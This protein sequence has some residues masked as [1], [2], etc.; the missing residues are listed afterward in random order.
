MRVSNQMTVDAS[1]SD[2]YR[3]MDNLM[4]SQQ[5]LSSQ[6]RVNSPSDDPFSAYKAIGA[7]SQVSIIE[8]YSKNIDDI[9][10][11]VGATDT[12]LTSVNEDLQEVRTLAVSAANGTLDDSQR[13]TIAD[14]VD[15]LRD[16]IVQLGNT[17]YTDRYLFSGTNTKTKP[18]TWSGTDVTYSGNS[19]SM[20]R[21][22]GP[23]AQV[24]TNMTG[25]EVFMGLTV[26]G[27]T[28][29]VFKLLNDLS[30]AM[31]ANNTSSVGDSLLQGVDDALNQV[32]EKLG[33]VGATENR[34]TKM[35]DALSTLKEKQTTLLSNAEDIDI[36]EATI[37]LQTNQNAYQA[38]LAA[39]AK[40]ILPSLIDY[41][42]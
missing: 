42:K 23:G 3:T 20:N 4:K 33:Q 38:T 5:E 19:A 22:I 2:L 39:T 27:S 28:S 9:N 14:Q 21:D 31:R 15:Q 12:A 40:V 36:A 32:E 24:K 34:L 29:N 41:L 1:L 18:F 6:K 10:G 13:G 35:S 8:Q 7:R 25:E 17:K 26:N 30:T 37:N 16:A 11:W